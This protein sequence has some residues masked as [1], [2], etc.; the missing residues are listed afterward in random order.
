VNME[1][2]LKSARR[3]AAIRAL[4]WH[5]L[6]RTCGCRLLQDHAMSIEGVKEW[7]G[8][9]SV[10]TTERAYAFI[11]IEHLH[12]TVQKSAQA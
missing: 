4:R 1:K 8:H 6:R 3:R 11:E 10:I 7:L 5:D 2:G 9:E 12:R